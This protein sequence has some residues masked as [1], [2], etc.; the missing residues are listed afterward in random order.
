M[1][2]KKNQNS[3]PSKKRQK[4]ESLTVVNIKMMKHQ[5]DIIHYSS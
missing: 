2:V 1:F 5:C 3:K 4:L